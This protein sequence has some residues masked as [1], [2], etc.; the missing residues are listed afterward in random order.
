MNPLPEMPSYF[1]RCSSYDLPFTSPPTPQ[2]QKISLSPVLTVELK[3]SDEC[4][5]CYH[6][7]GGQCR[8]NNK[9]IFYC[10]KDNNTALKLG[11][12][13]SAVGVGVLIMMICFYFRTKLSSLNLACNNKSQTHENIKAF[14]RNHEPL[15]IRRYS[16]NEIKKMTVSFKDKLGQGGYGSVYKGKLH[17]GCPVAAKVLKE[18]KGNGEEFINEVASI[19][20]TSHVNI[21]TLLGF[22]FEGAKRAL[23]YE[24][25]PNGSLEK[26]IYEEN[27]SNSNNE[28]ACEILHKIAVG[29][30]RGLEYLHRGCNTR[31]LHFDIKP[32]NILLDGNFFPKISDFGL[33]KICP[34]NE[35]II[36]ILGARGTAGYI[37]PEVF[38]RSFGG[39][40]HKSDVYSYGMMVLEM[41]GG[42]KN[43]NVKADCSSEIYFPHWIY[44]RLELNEELAL[45][46]ITKEG[47][48]ERMRK[49]AIVGLWCIQ[50][51]PSNRPTM[52]GVVEML[53]GSVESLQVP[54]KP[55]LSSPPS[56]P[57][58]LSSDTISLVQ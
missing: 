45:R 39:V 26:F 47:D 16:Y 28:L 46:S 41:V 23:V 24:F 13:A 1:K 35:S 34:R 58:P 7:R 12:V 54:P 44:K 53:E 6:N 31:I 20:R 14:L 2:D 27:Q 49:M 3:L 21:V 36:S 43:I 38:S 19:S 57:A 10:A 40:S 30:A 22:C 56:S 51:N 29:V 5:D 9:G 42:R 37:A 50:T 11:L 8:L 48:K 33:S 32:H 55:Y 17:D 15:A 4:R 52:G 25:M 18:S